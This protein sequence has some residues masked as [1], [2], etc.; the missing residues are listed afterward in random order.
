M[1]PDD[2]DKPSEGEGLN[3]RAVVKLEGNWPVDKS[4]REVIRD[5]ERIER[6]GYC[7]KL[8]RMT[9]K[10]GATFQDYDPVSGTCVFEVSP[11]K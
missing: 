2:T 10:I 3:K 6:M 4:T 9:E 7:H 11:A 5:A 1:Y 8:K